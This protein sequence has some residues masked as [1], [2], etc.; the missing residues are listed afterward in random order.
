MDINGK[1]ILITGANRGIG[2]ATA[3]KAGQLT[4]G[5]LE[6]QNTDSIYQMFNINL[7]GLVHLIKALLPI[8][9][10]LR[11]ELSGTG[12]STL[13]LIKPGV[14]TRMYDKISDLYSDNVDLKILSS[15]PSEDWVCRVFEHI[16]HDK[17]VRWP[18]VKYYIGVKLGQHMPNA[19]SWITKGYFKR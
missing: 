16:K 5:L 6:N 12:V 8:T 2:L 19:L 9:E 10:S 17:K 4:G 7:V 3:E 13:V 1:N 11:H 18:S 14:K 15:T